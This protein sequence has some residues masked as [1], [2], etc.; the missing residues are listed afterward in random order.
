[1][2]GEMVRKTIKDRGETWYRVAKDSGVPYA[3]LY[4]FVTGQRSIALE[5]L[6][7]LCAYLGL[8]LTHKT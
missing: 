2:L 4:R 3:T 7:K 5:S 6:E 8:E 1:M